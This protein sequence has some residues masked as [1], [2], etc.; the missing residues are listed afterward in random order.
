MSWLTKTNKLINEDREYRKKN[1]WPLV[2]MDEVIK[3]NKSFVFDESMTSCG[4]FTDTPEGDSEV[5]LDD[6][7]ADVGLHNTEVHSYENLNMTKFP[8]LIINQIF[9]IP[10]ARE[11]MVVAGGYIYSHILNLLK[12]NEIYK[13]QNQSH[14]DI[15][16][17]FYRPSTDMSND[18]LIYEQIIESIYQIIV[19]KFYNVIQSRN[20]YVHNIIFE[21]DIDD[22]D[23]GNRIIL[24]F[25]TKIFD[26]KSSIIGQF[27]I[28]SASVL[29]DG[30][31][32]LFTPMGA[33]SYGTYYNYVDTT[34]AS[35][36]FEYRLYKYYC[37]KNGFGIAFPDC[38][39]N[40][41]ALINFTDKKNEEPFSK[42]IFYIN[43]YIP[44]QQTLENEEI[45]G[46][47]YSIQK[48]CTLYIQNKLNKI[49]FKLN[50]K[51]QCIID[52][53]DI[54]LYYR[55]KI[56]AINTINNLKSL[57][58]HDVL[59]KI[60]EK[61]LNDNDHYDLQVA[62]KDLFI[63]KMIDDIKKFIDE[64]Y[65]IKPGIKWIIGEKGDNPLG[66]TPKSTKEWYGKYAL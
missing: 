33:Y 28:P 47:F 18:T 61:T 51:N 17:F 45:Y 34:R 40:N 22:P 41:N 57:Y 37:T 46:G 21:K 56:P 44:K 25:I 42:L 32:L 4:R 2:G 43:T 38:I 50:N 6:N 10:G 5:E 49:Y 15:D 30:T 63:K 23:I 39:L 53:N 3:Y 35:A 58:P 11:R 14:I 1:V 29:Y 62:E 65:N 54:Y 19:K 55:N 59:Q 36:T 31:Q 8:D 13:N 16:I 7:E 27:D 66:P 26:N 20:Q 12:D 52:E 48:L 64:N 60:L 24:Q 9:E